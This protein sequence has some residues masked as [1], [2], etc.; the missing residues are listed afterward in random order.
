MKKKDKAP[1]G[2]SKVTQ[3]LEQ[4]DIYNKQQLEKRAGLNNSSENGSNNSM[5]RENNS[6]GSNNSN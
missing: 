4:M 5:P 6:G 1:T 3:Y 2:D